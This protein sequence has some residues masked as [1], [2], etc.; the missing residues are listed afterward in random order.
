MKTRL[1]EPKV[2]KVKIIP[3]TCSLLSTTFALGWS[4][5]GGLVDDLSLD[6]SR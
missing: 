2:L 1:S 4:M 3:K 5:I 6:G